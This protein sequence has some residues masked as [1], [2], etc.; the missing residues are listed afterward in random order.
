MAAIGLLATGLV[1]M[2]LREGYTFEVMPL[3][4]E[5]DS[6]PLELKEWHG[7]DEPLPDDGTREILNAQATIHRTYQNPG[8]ATLALTV[9]AWLRPET[10]S[11]AAPHIPKLCYTNAGWQIVEER[12]PHLQTSR[13]EVPL[14]VYLFERGEQRIVV[15]YWYQMDQNYFTS[16][17]EARRVHRQLWGQ[18]HWPATLKVLLQANSQRIETAWPTIERLALLLHEELNGDVEHAEG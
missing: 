3:S 10:I 8:G 5:L 17:E 7:E 14:K 11:T 9:S 12:D 15:A 4:K 2:K 13:G 18:R 1:T 16:V 6:V